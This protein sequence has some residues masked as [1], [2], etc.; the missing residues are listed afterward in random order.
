MKTNYSFDVSAAELYGW[1]H[2]G[3]RLGLLAKGAEADPQLLLE[4]INRYQVTHIN[5]VPSVFSVVVD[6]LERTGITTIESVDHI[7]LAGEELPASLVKRFYAINNSIQLE[8]IYGPTE[9]T[10]YSCSYSIDRNRDYDKI[11]IGKPV[12]NVRLYILDDSLNSVPVGVSGELYISGVN[13]AEG[14]L[15]QPELTNEK[16]IDSP[17]RNG[18]KLY[19][20]GDLTKW[21]ENG[22]VTFLGRRDNQVK[23]R[24]YRIELGD[25]QSHLASYD[26]IND[27]VVIVRE[28]GNNKF[29]FGYYVSTS[30]IENDKLVS[31]LKSRLPEYMIPVQFIHLTSLPVTSNG[32][33]NHKALPEANYVTG[34]EFI[35]PITQQEQIV[36]G[37][38]KKMLGLDAVSTNDNFFSIGGDS[39]KSIQVSSRLRSLGYDVSVQEIFVSPTIG[40]LA[41]KLIQLNNTSYQ[42]VVTG[43]AEVTPIQKWFFEGPIHNKN[44]FHHNVFLSLSDEISESDVRRA[45]S[46]ILEHHDALRMTFSSEGEKLLQ[47]NSGTDMPLHLEVMR[48]E[49]IGSEYEDF[50]KKANV[51]QESFDIESG[52]LMKLTMFESTNGNGLLITIH[53]LVIDGISWRILFED[54]EILFNQINKSRKLELPLKTDSFL[55]WN[56]KITAYKQS[57]KYKKGLKYWTEFY[58]QALPTIELENKKGSNLGSERISKSLILDETTTNRLLTDA[59]TAYNTQ[60][61]DILLTALANA[62]DEK[63]GGG[64]VYVDLESHGRVELEGSNISRTIGWFT[65]IYPTFIPRVDGSLEDMVK[66][67]KENLRN[68]PNG[69]LDFLLAQEDILNQQS[70]RPQVIFNYLGQFDEDTE[71]DY[72]NVDQGI[73]SRIDGIAQNESDNYAINCNGIVENGQLTINFAF[74]PSQIGEEKISELARRY[75][76]S[77]K[78]L[79]SYCTGR[80]ETVLTPSDLTYTE[81]SIPLLES[82]QRLYEVQDI[83]P[84]SPMQDGMLFHSIYDRESTNYVGLTNLQ[85]EGDVNVEYIRESMNLLIDRYTVLRTAFLYER[86]D[87]NLQIVLDKREIDLTYFDER[88]SQKP[89]E[90]IITFYKET[91]INKP[92]D[93]SKDVLM[94]IVVVQLDNDRYELIWAQHHIL[95]DGWCMSLIIQDFFKAYSDKLS[96]KQSDFQEVVPYARYIKWLEENTDSSSLA[97]WK[98]RLDGFTDPVSIPRKGNASVKREFNLNRHSFVIQA[99]VT[100]RLQK[101]CKSNG[102]TINTLVQCSWAVLLSKY[103]NTKDVV[104]GSVVSGRPSEVEGIESMVGLFI[105]TIPVRI[106]LEG[107][108]RLS[109]LLKSVHNKSVESNPHHYL[110]LAE[111]QSL[112]EVENSLFDHILVFENFPVSQQFQEDDQEAKLPFHVRNTEYSVKTNYDLSVKIS[113]N[114]DLEFDFDYNSHL[115]SCDMICQ[116]GKQLENLLMQ[117]AEN[118]S[119]RIIDLEIFESSEVEDIKAT[120]SRDIANGYDNTIQNLLINGFSKNPA[121]IAI[122]YKG[123][124]YTYN[125]VD[126]ESNRIAQAIIDSQ[127]TSP[128]S[129]GVL[130][131]D[132]YWMIVSIIGILKSGN[133]FVPLEPSLPV[134]R[135]RSMVDQ[136]SVTTIV[137]DQD[138]VLINE[139]LTGPANTIKVDELL[140]LSTD[141]VSIEYGTDDPVYVYFTSGSTGHPKG[142]L[143]RNVSLAHFVD[144]EINAFEID[145]NFRFSQFTN[146]GFDVFMRDTIVPL[147]A[148]ATICIPEETDITTGED[149]VQWITDSRISLIHCVPSFFKVFNSKEAGIANLK[150]L[151]FI[152]LAGEKAPVGEVSRWYDHTGSGELINIYGPTET[153]LAKGC[154]KIPQDISS[155]HHYV[156]ILPIPGAQFMIL[157]SD[158]KLCVEGAIGEIY[159][160]TPF[161]SKGYVSS[162]GLN[163]KVF[164][165]NPYSNNENDFIYKTGDLGKYWNG[166]HIEILGRADHQVKVRG[167]RIELDDIRENI[168]AHPD[169]QDSI[170]IVDSDKGENY[171]VAYLV[172]ENELSDGDIKLYLKDRLPRNMIPSFIVK[173]DRIPQLPNGKVDRKALPKPT[174]TDQGRATPNNPT[175]QKLVMIF[176]EVLRLTEAEV[177]TNISFFDMG[178]HSIRAISLINKVRKEFDVKI[179][180]KQ[181]F[182]NPTIKDIAKILG[183]SQSV[184]D[185]SIP[186]ANYK[187]LYNASPAQE[188]MYYQHSLLGGGTAYNISIPVKI[189]KEIDVKRIENSF[190]LLI[191]KH[192]GLRTSFVMPE[193]KVMQQVHDDVSFKIEHVYF[194]N[195]S[196][197]K[198]FQ[199]FI[200][201]FDLSEKHL[202]RVAYLKHPLEGDY[203]FLD[204]HHIVCDGYSLNILIED[205][206]T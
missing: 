147:C 195:L 129:V 165:S 180:L 198:V 127:S 70:K 38:W 196:V 74:S 104:F 97:Y 108:D 31:Y 163:Q 23:I 115:Y 30:E 4:A 145:H 155:H 140:G 201:P 45:F 61:N 123:Y 25:I 138:N 126:I 28:K 174:L 186:K 205:F 116:V 178:G 120:Y 141:P 71:S 184:T 44:H 5:F 94:R 152:L 137:S 157:D 91:E 29:L 42:G 63:F 50:V 202:I 158:M 14:Y 87:K 135:L 176:A 39:I 79:I 7:F 60:I 13:L 142:V 55:G 41:K 69:G 100:D 153:T 82:I 166:G 53:H 10:I 188:R 169:V 190:I 24:G 151:R 12:S 54:I 20:T 75:E 99:G 139:I 98:N 34:K 67:T 107:L 47:C 52:P 62:F 78:A 106:V 134:N 182:D 170:V 58:S 48:V 80:N 132:R 26:Q 84:L 86:V 105:N 111:I 96:N 171:I 149:I 125:D 51:V 191:S 133:I 161:C 21:D 93:L 156:P 114:T 65:T 66:A 144:W 90:D 146:P 72:F 64:G 187:K 76:E 9:G 193:D 18:E 183:K 192:S 49:G 3:G 73:L 128:V 194:S 19:K 68:I 85:I 109:D 43:K 150:D 11:P 36:A 103:N 77:L 59:H 197:E 177:G 110:P 124:C 175:E 88:N 95:M 162:D 203:L 154:Y 56:K 118:P 81:V 136:V 32:K 17:F 168:I 160:R 200:R 164:I 57:K 37:V 159:I 167:I 143:G 8:N 89:E 40:Q 119:H 101:I 92:F 113:L 206:L 189:K 173:L 102:I 204:I 172:E 122:E 83:Y 16:F 185:T 35:A 22:N 2:A 33:L 131:Q 112:S 199:K 181:I 130:C 148:G 117:I 6:E 179:E 27:A 46:K 1:Y 121:H 15:N